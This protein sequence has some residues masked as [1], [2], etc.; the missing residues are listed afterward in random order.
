MKAFLLSMLLIL[1]GYL[2]TKAQ[3]EIYTSLEVD[4]F[5]II[6]KCQEENSNCFQESLKIYIQKNIDI[7]SLTKYTSAKA[8]AQFVIMAS[9]EIKN[10]KVRTT[11]KDLKKEA[12]KLLNDLKIESP[13]MLNGAPVS[14]IYTTPISFSS[15]SINAGTYN[16]TS[17]ILENKRPSLAFEDA[18]VLPLYKECKS[19]GIDSCFEDLT[20]KRII[21]FLKSSKK[22]KMTLK[23]GMELKIYFEIET[24]GQFSNALVVGGND[25]IMKELPLLINNMRVSEA[26]KNKNNIY[27]AS[28][29]MKTIVL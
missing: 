20:T 14:M 18:T 1:F 10:I 4:D 15:M 24:N 29:F 23:A 16:P 5:P 13:A 27:V 21:S 22:L 9:G 28:F 8:Y 11:N 2:N 25:K 26:A 7:K 19:S 17:D 3:T 12:I 6:E